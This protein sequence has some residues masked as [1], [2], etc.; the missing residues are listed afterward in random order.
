[1][2]QLFQT[3]TVPLQS[4]R[5]I[6]MTMLGSG[7]GPGSYPAVQR[8]GS[9]ATD[10]HSELLPDL[11]VHSSE[12]GLQ[13][14]GLCQPRCITLPVPRHPSHRAFAIACLHLH[15]QGVHHSSCLSV[16]LNVSM[17]VT[18]PCVLM[19]LHPQGALPTAQLWASG[20]SQERTVDLM[21]LRDS[22][23]SSRTMMSLPERC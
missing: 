17:L 16:L 3:V 1:M 22:L 2:L 14:Q 7:W 13:R 19:A 5:E 21:I 10:C 11:A 4:S 6:G 20:A 9:R 12:L 23:N 8:R 15:L 18:V